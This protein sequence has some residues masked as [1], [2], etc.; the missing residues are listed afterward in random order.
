MLR[1]CSRVIALSAVVVALST[2]QAA[3]PATL[4]LAC[5]GTVVTGPN[6]R[7]EPVSMGITV[8]FTARTVQ[9]L[10]IPPAMMG[11]V[12]LGSTDFVEITGVN[13]LTVAFS[14][15]NSNQLFGLSVT[16]SI[17][18]VTGDLEADYI[19][20]RLKTN[21]IFTTQTLALKCRPTQ[22]MFKKAGDH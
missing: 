19:T 20:T 14:G 8:N 18:R 5:Q 13:D 12:G 1:A 6:G 10:D 17:D 11:I 16:G 4:M 2:A 21:E 3:E 9:G 22:R 7:P 15:N